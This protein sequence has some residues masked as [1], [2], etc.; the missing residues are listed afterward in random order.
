MSRKF[1]PKLTGMTAQQ[2][3]DMIAANMSANGYS[4]REITFFL[5]GATLL[6]YLS[7]DRRAWMRE[8]LTRRHFSTIDPQDSAIEQAG[9]HKVPRSF[10][11]DNG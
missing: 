9:S 4:E 6:G 10:F 7:D 2:C 5:A 3:R 1:S 8:F 11:S